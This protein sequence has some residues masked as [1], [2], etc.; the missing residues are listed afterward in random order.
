M[1]RLSGNIQR[2]GIIL[3]RSGVDICRYT[4]SIPVVRTYFLESVLLVGLLVYNVTQERL[5]IT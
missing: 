2:H 3:L 4:S 5:S 1:D